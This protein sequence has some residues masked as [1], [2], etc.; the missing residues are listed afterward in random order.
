V[1][2]VRD[3]SE[4]DLLRRLQQGD[5]RAF[6]ALF[7][8]Y[9][10]LVYRFAFSYLKSRPAAEEI[11][12]EC[13]IKIWEKRAQLRDDVP[14]KGYL[15]T[16]A[17]HAVLNE[18]RRDQHHLRLHGEVAAAAGPASVANEAEYQEMEALYAAA[19]DRLPPKQREVF[20]LSRQLG[21]SYPE[22]AARQGVSVKTVEAHIMQALKTMR[23]YFRLHGG[24]VLGIL[25]ALIIGQK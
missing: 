10:A 20:V 25:L 4:S 22:I 8:H 9:S 18:L 15:F 24:G 3:F 7:R 12:Q 1:E 2:I 13:F 14:L 23:S 21:L 19:L 16:T 17:H 5:E 11:V 6:D